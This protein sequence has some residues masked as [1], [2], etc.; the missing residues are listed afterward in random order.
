MDTTQTT[1]GAQ[2]ADQMQQS[3][4][5]PAAGQNSWEAAAKPDAAPQPIATPATGTIP[6]QAA[7]TYTPPVV[8]TPQHPKGILGVVASVRDALT[9]QT[10]PEIATDQ[11]GNKYVKETTLTHGE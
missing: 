1:S 11:Q 2:A 9:G 5:P 8:L 7:P 3:V 4:P 10:R 6:E